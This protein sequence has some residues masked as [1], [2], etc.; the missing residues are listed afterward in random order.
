VKGK[1]AMG[2][3]V[4][5]ICGS[6]LLQ[7]LLIAGI[8]DSDSADSGA[9]NEAP[10]S[11]NLSVMSVL[12]GSGDRNAAD[13]DALREAADR[14]GYRL[15]PAEEQMYTAEELERA[16]EEARKEA[17]NAGGVAADPAEGQGGETDAQEQR[18][19]LIIP[20]GSNLTDVAKELARLALIDDEQRFINWMKE[21]KLQRRIV[22]GYYLF[23]GA[24]SYE[25]I[26]KV[27]SR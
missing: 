21:R 3:G 11:A 6:L 25:D 20:S 4:G 1:F 18:T 8:P 2:V 23:N 16:V 17:G 13:E 22:A 9:V 27:I 12:G 10:S 26:A 19:E 14:L 7:L 5:M 24:P 15:V